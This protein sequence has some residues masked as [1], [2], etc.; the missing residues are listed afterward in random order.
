[1]FFNNCKKKIISIWVPED[2]WMCAHVSGLWRK[3]VSHSQ[4]CSRNC[5]F[6]GAQLLDGCSFSDEGSELRSFVRAGHTHS[7][8][9]LSSLI[10]VFQLNLGNGIYS[11]LGLL[12]FIIFILTYDTGISYLYFL[13]LV[14][15]LKMVSLSINLI[16][17][18]SRSKWIYLYRVV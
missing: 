14:S 7:D 4:F 2:H 16:G 18:L 13:I 10:L 11:L 3:R 17:L 6:V 5:E 12:S 9:C 1:M 15:V 8:S